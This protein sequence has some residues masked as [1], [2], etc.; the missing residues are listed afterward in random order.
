VADKDET[1]RFLLRR[2]SVNDVLAG[3]SMHTNLGGPPNLRAHANN[4][5]LSEPPQ[6]RLHSISLPVRVIVEKEESHIL[7]E[8]YGNVLREEVVDPI[9]LLWSPRRVWVRAKAVHED[10][11]GCQ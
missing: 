11:A 6:A 7:A 5:A 8:R 4:Y 3:C 9:A 10:D 2:T 1:A